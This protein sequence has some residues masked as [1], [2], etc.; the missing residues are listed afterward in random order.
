MIDVTGKTVLWVDS[1]K[2]GMLC[3]ESESEVE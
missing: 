3:K 2:M 1:S